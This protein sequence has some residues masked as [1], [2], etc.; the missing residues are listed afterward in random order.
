MGELKFSCSNCGQHI[1]AD[2]A[3][4]GQKL[5]CPACQ[6]ELVVPN[7]ATLPPPIPTQPRLAVSAAPPIIREPH[8][9]A[10]T[11]ARQ[12][13]KK[14][15]CGLGPISVLLVVA[16]PLVAFFQNAVM[17]VVPLT[18]LC[19]IAGLICGHVALH[20]IRVNPGL[21]GR[22]W[23]WVGLSAG[24]LFALVIVLSIGYIVSVKRGYIQTAQSQRQQPGFPSQRFPRPSFPQPG[25]PQSQPRP[26]IPQPGPGV[27]QPSPY[28]PQPG[29]APTLPPPS[30]PQPGRNRAGP[31]PAPPYRM[32]PGTS[33]IPVKNTVAGQIA[34]QPF[35]CNR[36]RLM[37]SM[38]ELGQGTE[39]ILDTSVTVFTMLTDDPSGR[40]VI[41]PVKSDGFNPHVNL[42]WQ[43]GGRVRI[44]TAMEGFTMRLEFGKQSGNL[45]PGKLQLEIPGTPVTKLAGEF[46]AEVR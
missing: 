39:F 32:A 28:T 24:Y 42:R 15:L 37:G 27:P 1:A 11:P 40:T 45:I 30:L 16:T 44:D 13:T 4:R 35:R 43:E 10:S 14:S 22:V 6:T 33:S 26:A 34:G 21:S 9:P 5:N 17:P 2:E 23:A 29:S 46:T 38:L 25:S 7:A 8:R 41:A 19:L 3:W 18:P 36:A 20:R 12:P 31:Q